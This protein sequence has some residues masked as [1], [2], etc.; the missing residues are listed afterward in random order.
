MTSEKRPA[1]RPSEYNADVQE[2]ADR[3]LLDGYLEHDGVI[4]SIAGLACYLGVSRSTI[5]YWRDAYPEF[6]GTLEAISQ[7]QE[8]LTLSGG[9]SNKFNSTIAKLVLANH[10][11]SDKQDIAHTSPDGSMTPKV[12][13]IRIIGG[14]DNA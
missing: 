7:K 3:Y 10:G 11:Y 5:H 9:L 13:A 8:H 4:P 6:S 1:H 12:T 14:D 2:Q